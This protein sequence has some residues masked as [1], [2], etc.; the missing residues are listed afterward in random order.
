MKDLYKETKWLNFYIVERKPKTVVMHVINTKNQF[1]G[2]IRW[3]GAW[4]QYVYNTAPQIVY[5]NR[6]LQD[7]TDVLTEL[8]DAQKEQ[9]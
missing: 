7:I 3:L 9:K 6:C 1:L 5:N 4:R 2:E 8:N